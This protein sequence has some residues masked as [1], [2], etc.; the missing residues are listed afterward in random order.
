VLVAKG[1]RGVKVGAALF[2]IGAMFS[3]AAPALAGAYGQK[4]YYGPLA[5]ENYWNQNY[6]DTSPRIYA[7]TTVSTNGTGTAPGGYMGVYARL[8]K[9]SSLC[10]TRG[11]NYNS[12]SA[13]ALTV[14]TLGE[15]CGGGNYNSHG[16]T[17][18]WHGTGYY[19][20]GS[21]ASPNQTA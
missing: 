10:A 12:G 3:V 4:G 18:G 17:Q 2:L 13:S 15:G 8:Y 1:S 14:P 7:S 11:W 19:T 9:G 20:Y 16:L 5:G 21:F 6:V